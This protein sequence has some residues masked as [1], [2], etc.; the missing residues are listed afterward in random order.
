MSGA[1]T[2]LIGGFV[3]DI[4]PGKFYPRNLTP[5]AESGLGN[6]ADSAIARAL[7]YGVGHD[8]R[9]LLPFMEMQGLSDDDLV[10][11]VSYLR[12]QAPVHNVV[13][14]HSFNV[15]GQDCEGDGDV[16]SGRS[17]IAAAVRRAPRRFGGDGT[18]PRRVGRALR[19][20]SHGA[21][22]DDRRP[23]RPALWRDDE[24]QGGRRSESFVG[25]AEHPRAIGRRAASAS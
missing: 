17:V 16:S 8:G 12:T 19:G 10:A 13:P 7:R 2:P 5:D 1:D 21:Q 14:Q 4:P 20:V 9:V 11:V 22:S 23:H 6:V 24:L 3:C 15:P 18:L 25:A